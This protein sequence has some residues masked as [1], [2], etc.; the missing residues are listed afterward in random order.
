V[1]RFTAAREWLEAKVADVEGVSVYS[2]SPESP[3]LPA[4]VISGGSP[5]IGG[6]GSTFGRERVNLTLSILVGVG[7]GNAAGLE[8]IEEIVAAVLARVPNVGPIEAPANETLSTVNA[9]RVRVPV[10]VHVSDDE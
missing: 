4:L 8:R 3:A 6:P 1:N 9:W 10:S 5:W 2:G 7:A